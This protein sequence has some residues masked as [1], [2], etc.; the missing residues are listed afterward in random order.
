MSL[1]VENIGTPA[2]DLMPRGDGVGYKKNSSAVIWH[3]VELC[4]AKVI[5]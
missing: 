3:G 5:Q 2:D 1:D 4:C